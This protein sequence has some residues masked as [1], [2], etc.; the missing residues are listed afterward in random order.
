VDSTYQP[1]ATPYEE[2]PQQ[3]EAATLGMWT[4][5]ATE[6]LFF[7]AM[8]LSYTVYRHSFP[9]AFALASHH[10]IVLY[11]TINTAIL[12]TSS[13]T[14]ALAVHAAKEGNNK[15]VFRFL[16][17]TILFALAFLVVK[18]FE[19]SEDVKE[20]LWPGKN[21]R[22]TL[23]PQ[24]QIFWVLYWIMTGVHAVHVTVGICVIAF[25]AR[26]ATKQKFSEQYHTPVEMTGLY[27]H[28]V[29]IIWIFLYPLLYLIN[30]YSA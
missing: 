12:L 2:V 4:F 23:P 26:M 24:A 15:L 22:P 29:D 5:L 3:K 28:F 17:I 27:W 19:Y 11:G 14:M 13:L 18:G 20:H 21:F 9:D 10:T 25:V 7:G 1:L 6:I 30:R 16:G 8:F